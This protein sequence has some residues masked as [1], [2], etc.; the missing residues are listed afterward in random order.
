[1]IRTTA[2]AASFVAL[3][4]GGAAAFDPSDMSA[5]EKEAFG[6]AVREYLLE[7][8]RVL[9]EAVAVLEQRE[10]EERARA[11]VALISEL[12]EEIFEDDFSFIGGNPD[13]DVVMVE[14]IDY[15]CSY[16]RKAHPEIA[17]LLEADGRIKKIIKEFPI[18]GEESVEASRF[19]I[20]VLQ[21]DGPEAYE[22]INNTLIAHRG[23]FTR[24]TLER[25][26]EDKGLSALKIMRRMDSEEVSA[27]IRAN[28]E[29]AQKLE[30]NGTPGFVF[31]DRM[32][33]GY[34]PLP[35]MMATVMEVRTQ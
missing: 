28:H 5:S 8:P 22:D 17:R 16:C 7:N 18:L 6:A 10:A 21:I 19:A 14:F 34:L 9:M 1:M 3:T 27:V 20:S 13:G 4:A 30:I 32:V 12:S 23:T 24:D 29:L 2:L 35:Q 15:R 26:A 11:E 33:R 25:I 31:K